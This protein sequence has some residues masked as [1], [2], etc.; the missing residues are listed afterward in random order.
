MPGETVLKGMDDSTIPSSQWRVIGLCMLFNVIDGLDVM[1]MA[2]TGGSV[3]AQWGLTGAQLG[4]LL[5]A[6]LVGMAFGS[7]L[8]GPRADRY[9]RRPLLLAGLS[10]SGL[11]MLL[12]FWSPNL[13]LLMILRLLTGI[14]T[15]AVLVA[16]NVLTYER[17]S[18]YRR[19][20]AIALQSM[21]FA[22]G[23]SLGGLLAHVL[24]ASV[25]G[26]MCFS[27]VD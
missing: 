17:A 3:S 14:G 24:N 10:L 13:Y 2:F 8:V 21:A 26:V 7:L 25:A 19:N 27:S 1:A 23:A 16:A 4:L 6:S 11:S 22:L 20:L 15:G 18:Q 12:S 5:S 9:G